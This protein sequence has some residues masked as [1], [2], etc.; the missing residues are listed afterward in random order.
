[1]TP[2][3]TGDRAFA[4]D[5]AAVAVVAIAACAT[6]GRLAT[7]SILVPA[8][9]VARFAAWLAVPRADRDLDALPEGMVFTLATA[10]GAVND[11]NTV[12]RHGVYAYTV[13]SD[14]GALSPIPSWMLLYWGLILRFVLTVFHYRR[15]AI[16][17]AP[18]RVWLGAS[19]RS[20]APIV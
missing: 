19:I 16:P 11:W 12:S 15:L 5:A 17:R 4:I 14:L 2:R 8:V 10:L 1:M 9:I 20:A 7:M 13:P 18:D 6:G 3:P